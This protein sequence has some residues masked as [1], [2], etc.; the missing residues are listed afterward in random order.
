MIIDILFTS[1]THRQKGYGHTTENEEFAVEDKVAPFW[2][3]RGCVSSHEGKYLEVVIRTQRLIKFSTPRL[4][5]FC[6]IFY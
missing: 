3:Y 1:N 5:Y 2:R 6:S 4:V